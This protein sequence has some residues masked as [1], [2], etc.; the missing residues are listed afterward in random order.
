[1][2]RVKVWQTTL[3]AVASSTDEIISLYSGEGTVLRVLGEL[4]GG[5]L[6]TTAGAAKFYRWV[7][8]HGPAAASATPVGLDD[9]S[10]MLRGLATAPQRSSL[11]V[12]T[13]PGPILV[14]TEGQRVLDPGD[15]LWLR[16]TTG[17]GG[18]NWF[19]TWSIRVLILL[20]EA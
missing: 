17:S 18:T 8:N 3:S 5:A 20:P 15:Q 14:Q 4:W 13:E 12:Y 7:V 2:A 1:M 9:E 19:W 6:S 16:L 11:A 10:V